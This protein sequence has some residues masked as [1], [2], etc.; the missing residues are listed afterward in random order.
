MAKYILLATAVGRGNAETME[1]FSTK[2]YHNLE[3]VTAAIR[4][5]FGPGSWRLFP[6]PDFQNRW[7]DKNRWS[8]DGITDSKQW[9]SPDFSYLAV[10]TIKGEKKK[11]GAKNG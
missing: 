3:E 2:K 8:D 7:N 1:Q 4:K 5:V 11:K 9:L 10:V 6:L